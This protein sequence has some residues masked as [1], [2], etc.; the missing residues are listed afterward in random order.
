MPRP[1]SDLQLVTMRLSAKVLGDAEDLASR[2]SRGGFHVTRSDVLRAAIQRG[3]EQMETEA[4]PASKP[5]GST[6][7]RAGRTR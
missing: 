4:G 2:M 3:L 7:T 1:P 5:R 6:R